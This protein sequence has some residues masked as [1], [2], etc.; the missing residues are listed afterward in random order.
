MHGSANKKLK[1]DQKKPETPRPTT[2]RSFECP[3]GESFKRKG[4]RTRHFT[5]KHTHQ[6]VA[7][8]SPV[9]VVERVVDNETLAQEIKGFVGQSISSAVKDI[10][11]AQAAHAAEV[12]RPARG[13]VP[14]LDSIAEF[15]RTAKAMGFAVMTEEQGRIRQQDMRV[16]M[17][18]AFALGRASESSVGQIASNI[19]GVKR[20]ASEAFEVA[21]GAGSGPF[22][23]WCGQPS[24]GSGRYC[25]ACGRQRVK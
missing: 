1:K 19:I 12:A 18:E 5:S 9:K 25:S 17:L 24:S 16:G 8:H 13:S 14:L 21:P 2:P 3:C 7:K 20:T 11:E 22:C 10:S 4:D 23:Q 15:G 6:P